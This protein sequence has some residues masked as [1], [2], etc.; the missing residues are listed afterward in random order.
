[1]SDGLPTTSRSADRTLLPIRADGL[2]F[3][4]VGRRLVDNITLDISGDGVTAVIGPNG[5]GKT[6]LLRL[7]SGLLAPSS[8]RVTWG[9]RPPD[10]T[11]AR[12]LGILLQ[13]PVL[14]RRTALAN[15][16]Y[17]LTLRGM[18]RENRDAKARDMLRRAGLTHIGDTP[19]RLLSGGEQRRLALARTLVAEPA[20]LFLDEPA[21]NLDP[22]AAAAMERLILETRTAGVPILL[23]THDIGC[24]RRLAS[25]VLFMAQ[26]RIVEDGPAPSFFAKPQSAE[27]RAFLAGEIVL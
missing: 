7:L 10:E 23:I 2:V 17:P 15:L 1:M 19:A 4:G 16:A 8:G 5:A 26:G 9:G 25:R 24:A 18:S 13:Q 3:E 11:R 20:V 12:D 14:L 6:L 21:A 22:S 27:A